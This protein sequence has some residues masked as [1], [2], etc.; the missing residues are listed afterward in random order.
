MSKRIKKYHIEKG[1]HQYGPYSFKE[2]KRKKISRDTLVWFDPMKNWEKA[3]VIEE[4]QP[5]FKSNKKFL[6]WVPLLLLILLTILYTV[7]FLLSNKPIDTVTVQP[8]QDTL[9]QPISNGNTGDTSNVFEIDSLQSLS[10]TKNAATSSQPQG[11]KE[12]EDEEVGNEKINSNNERSI[13]I[14]KGCSTD[15]LVTYFGKNPS[16]L[17]GKEIV[18]EYLK[19]LEKME[20]FPKK[21]SKIYLFTCSKKTELIRLS[22]KYHISVSDKLLTNF[23]ALCP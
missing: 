23:K 11:E 12:Q 19:R 13:K 9:A 2:L 17:E 10:E 5:L 4:L 21:G 3:G 22:E 7:N 18:S 8:V 1:A 6:F 20:E 15:E 14:L 16:K